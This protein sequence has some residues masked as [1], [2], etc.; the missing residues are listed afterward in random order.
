MLLNSD[1][2]YDVVLKGE[3]QDGNEVALEGAVTL[4]ASDAEIAEVSDLGGG[5][6]L[7]NPKKVGLAQLIAKSGEIM[8]T[9]DIEVQPGA[10]F[11]I[12]V[13]LKEKEIVAPP[14]DSGSVS[15]GA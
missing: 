4:E 12:N 1:K 13:A 9:L 8:G 14:S 15:S 7:V 5:Q 2:Q 11:K 6:F 3:D 10:L